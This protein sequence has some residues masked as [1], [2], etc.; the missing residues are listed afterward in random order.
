MRRGWSIGQNLGES[1][2]IPP[3]LPP[4]PP[5]PPPPPTTQDGKEDPFEAEYAVMAQAR[6]ATESAWDIF[7][8]SAEKKKQEILE[9]RLRHEK[10]KLAVLQ[11]QKGMVGLRRGILDVKIILGEREN[12]IFE[13][14]QRVNYKNKKPVYTRINRDL[15]KAIRANT[16]DVLAVHIWY[17][18]GADVHLFHDILLERN[19]GDN[20]RHSQHIKDGYRIYRSNYSEEA[21]KNHWRTL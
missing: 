12:F 16:A 14:M 11:K 19:I 18:S 21:P 8:K 5:P 3:P 17:L 9:D 7:G 4:P 1:L 15:R 2:T 20:P 10:L 13:N 6:K